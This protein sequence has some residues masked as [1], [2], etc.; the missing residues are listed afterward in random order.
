MAASFNTKQVFVG[1]STEG[2]PYADIVIES[3]K[4]KGFSPL[5]W[6]DF[7]KTSRPPLQ[8]LEQLTLRADAAI[9]IA[10]ADDQAI[11]RNQNWHQMRDNVLFE[12]GLFAGTIGRAK[13]G[14]I[15][16]DTEDFRIP[17]DFLGVA[18]FKTFDGKDIN[19]AAKATVQSLIVT[20]Q[21]PQRPQTTELRGRRLLQLIGWIRDESL[22]LIQDWDNERGR[23]IVAARVVAVSGFI[24]EDVDQLTLRKEYEDLER[25]LLDSIKRFPHFEDGPEY[26]EYIRRRMEDMVSGYVPPN[27]EMLKGFLYMFEHERI[28]YRC[29]CQC[30]CCRYWRDRRNFPYGYYDYRYDNYRDASRHCCGPFA[31]A[32]GA[33]EAASVF[34]DMGASP[35]SQLK[36]WSKEFVSPLY[37][38]IARFERKLHEQ[39][40]G[41][42]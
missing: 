37:D 10:T 23:D 22:H 31:Y 2:K 14:L 41:I 32:L 35:I 13:C 34:R 30:D 17:S 5:A 33:A 18:C 16:P 36:V 26:R 29:D 25:L 42:L 6:F 21:T 7:F 4:E 28:P 27:R 19:S 38:A 1:S 9:L 40:F 15:I 11:I 3:L 20:M 39:I 8:E 12:Y 24:Q